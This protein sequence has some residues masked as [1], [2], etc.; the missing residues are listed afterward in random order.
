MC[1]CVHACVCVCICV[2]LQL[3]CAIVVH[4]DIFSFMEEIYIHL[5]LNQQVWMVETQQHTLAEIHAKLLIKDK[6]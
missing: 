4:G 6:R 5:H 3:G 2:W 1:V